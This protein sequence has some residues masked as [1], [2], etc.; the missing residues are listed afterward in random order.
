VR[1]VRPDAY[2]LIDPI[3]GD[4]GALYVGEEV[5]RAIADKLVPI[6]DAVTPNLFELAWLAGHALR[7]TAET[8]A[9]ARALG[10]AEVVVTSAPDA[11]AR[12]IR[13][14]VVT[15]DRVFA[16]D[17]DLLSHAVHGVGDL[18]TSLYV[19]YRLDREGPDGALRRATHGVV[20]VLAESRNR[21]ADE[22]ALTASQDHLRHPKG[23]V[24]FRRID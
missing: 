22:L 24:A 14:L 12:Q 9:A 6:A 16:A 13:S 2:V 3:M 5:A 19:G 7:H 23:H 15:K 21:N 17:A 8:V 1:A 11:P 10:P 20:S 4:D 18:L